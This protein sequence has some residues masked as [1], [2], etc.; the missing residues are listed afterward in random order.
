MKSLLYAA[1]MGAGA[2]IVSEV[3][4]MSAGGF[5]AASM[6]VSVVAFLLMAVGIWGLHRIQA[7]DKNALSLAGALLMSLSLVVFSIQALQ[8][9]SSPGTSA[10][11]QAATDPL[12]VVGALAMVVIASRM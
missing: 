10:A 2:W 5:S 11:G 3:L 8:F 1:V 9:L 12:F 4:E 6:W 7:R